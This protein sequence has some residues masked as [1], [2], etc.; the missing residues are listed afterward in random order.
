L[1]TVRGNTTGLKSSQVKALERIYNRRIPANELITPELARFM[2][3]LSYDIRRQIGILV[4]RQGGISH[5]IVGDDSEIYIPEL[6]RFK[7]A[8]AGLRGLRCIHTHLK[9]E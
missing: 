8:G 2:T 6:S 9:G 5:V 4:D 3:E 7:I 1:P